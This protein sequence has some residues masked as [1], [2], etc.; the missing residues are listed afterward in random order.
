MSKP[1]RKLNGRSAA[2]LFGFALV[3]ALTVLRASEPYPLVAAR[4]TAFDYYQQLQP[5]PA[6]DLPVLVVDIDETSLGAHGQWPWPRDLLA[7]LTERLGEMGAAAIAFDMLFAEPDRASPSRTI[8]GG[9][10]FDDEFAAALAATPSVLGLSDRPGAASGSVPLKTGIAVSGAQPVT[11]HPL[12]GV[13]QPL[14]GLATASTGLGVISLGQDDSGA[15]VRT[16]PLVWRQGETIVPTLALEALRVAAGET[17]IVVLGD[18]ADAGILESVRLGQWTVPTTASGALRLYYR[19]AGQGT[20]ISA[21]DILADG[22]VDLAGSVAGRIV[23]VGTSAAGLFDI[24]RTALGEPVAGVSIHAQAL[25][26]IL[27]GTYLHRADWVG[28]F[29]MLLFAAVGVVLVLAVTFAGP[30]VGLIV[31]FLAALGGAAASWVAFSNFGVLLDATFLLLGA[32]VLYAAMV[33]FRFA[34]TDADR[35]RLRNA[36]AHYVAPSL[37][38]EI[39][40]KADTLQLGGEVKDLSVMFCDVRNYTAISER[41]RPEELLRLLTTL[42]DGLGR[43]I[44]DENGTID[45]FM[46]DAIMAFWNA[47]LAVPEH[48]QHACRAALAMRRAVAALNTGDNLGERQPIAIGIGVAS[49]EALVGNMGSHDRFDYSCVGDTVNLA[50]RIEDACKHVHYDILLAGTTAEAV[51][52]MALLPG[53]CVSLKGVAERQPVHLLVGGK[54]LAGSPAFTALREKH[55]ALCARLAR[56]PEPDL[57]AE[58]RA[59]ASRIEPGLTVFYD[60]LVARAGDFAIPDAPGAAGSFVRLG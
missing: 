24:R 32:V 21:G 59:L 47:P 41:L 1:R 19:P 15:V 12:R 51:P 6:A 26:Q 49:G 18:T 29:E 55:E 11:I 8:P 45:K 36:F 22:H 35:R 27:A 44:T 39:E 14:P 4:E 54:D 20:T 52:E 58:C 9:P 33:F 38:A 3:A 5:R 57:L 10:D 60:T 34:V 42:F 43:C 50:A 48:P 25:E 13:V 2:I 56:R 31:S 17:T 30:K 37:L 16:L 53:G 28:G 23:F 7:T 40:E 46:G